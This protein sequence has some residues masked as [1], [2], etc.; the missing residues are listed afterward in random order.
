MKYF[1]D[2]ARQLVLDAL[3]KACNASKTKIVTRTQLMVVLG[4]PNEDELLVDMLIKRC[5]SDEIETKRGATGGYKLKGVDAETDVVDQ[6]F[7][8]NVH[9]HIKNRLGNNGKVSINDIQFDMNCRSR[10]M[11]T[12]ALEQLPQFKCIKGVGIVEK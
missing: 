12:K 5:L 9:Q 6:E 2:E 4:L 10:N 7:I 3:T 1:T 11:I 8:D